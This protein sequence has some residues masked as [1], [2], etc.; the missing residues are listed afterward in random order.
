MATLVKRVKDFCKREDA[1]KE[2][3]QE[4]QARKPKTPVTHTEGRKKRI[5]VGQ[6][7]SALFAHEPNILA[8]IQEWK[9]RQDDVIHTTKEVKKQEQDFAT[10]E[11]KVLAL[12][13]QRKTS[14]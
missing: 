8:A 11:T 3:D 2:I 6:L 9:K 12:K 4:D 13:E 1:Q 10:L 14:K 5:H 7:A